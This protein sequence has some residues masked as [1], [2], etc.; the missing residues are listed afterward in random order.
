MI[1]DSCENFVP[2]VNENLLWMGKKLVCLRTCCVFTLKILADL[3]TLGLKN[4]VR[5]VAPVPDCFYSAKLCKPA[6]NTFGACAEKSGEDTGMI[7]MIDLLCTDGANC[8]TGDQH[9]GF[10]EG[11]TGSD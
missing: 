7:A 3:M 2:K 6:P 10:G 5:P 11:C 4:C 8:C 1:G 9:Q